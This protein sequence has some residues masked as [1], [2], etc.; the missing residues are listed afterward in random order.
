MSN[1]YGPLPLTPELLAKL[2]E[3]FPDS[4]IYQG[5]PKADGFRPRYIAWD[6]VC[7][8]L[9]DVFG[10]NWTHQIHRFEMI[11]NQWVVHA[12]IRVM[13][14]DQDKDRIIEIARD[15]IGTWPL[16]MNGSAYLDIGDDLKSA[17]SEAV[18]RAAVK[19]GLGVQ[20]Y[21]REG[22]QQQNVQ[23]QQ[24]QVVNLAPAQPFQ[25]DAV[26]KAL[27]PYKMPV[28][29]LCQNLQVPSLDKLTA[30]VAAAILSGQHPLVAWLKQQYPQVTGGQATGGLKASNA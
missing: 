14:Y 26:K 1:V 7:K 5:E 4:D 3:P 16:S 29:W 2:R 27:E 20:L 17:E 22:T 12:S 19:F 21:N 24:Q 30:A 25:V 6:K 11:S 10:G 23:A 9:D 15:G 8:R 28:D 18:K 13:V